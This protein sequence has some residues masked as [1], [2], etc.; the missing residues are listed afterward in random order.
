MARA[1]CERT[2]AGLVATAVEHEQQLVRRRIDRALA[3]E[4]LDAGA[5][6]RLLVTCRNHDAAAKGGIGRCDHGAG[7]PASISSRPRS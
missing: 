5:D 4:R 3:G 2:Q 7:S 6:Q 1:P